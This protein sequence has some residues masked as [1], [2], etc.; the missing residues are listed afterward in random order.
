MKNIAN[1]RK[2]DPCFTRGRKHGCIVFYCWLES[3]TLRNKFGYLTEEINVQIK[4]WRPIFW[5]LFCF[6]FSYWCE[7]WEKQDKLKNKLLCK[8]E[9]EPDGLGNS[10]P[11]Q[12]AKATK[13]RRFNIR[14]VC[15][16]EKPKHATRQLLLKTLDMWLIDQ[17][18]HLGRTR[19]REVIIQETYVEKPLTLWF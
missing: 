3:R 18:N 1:Q 6:S 16:G 15:S 5:L 9:S 17:F 14:K 11:N 2:D 8:K 4:C 13:I 7:V 12:I 10:Q 19:T